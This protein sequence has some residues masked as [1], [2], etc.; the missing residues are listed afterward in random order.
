MKAVSHEFGHLLHYTTSYLGLTHFLFWAKSI[1]AIDNQ[2]HE[3]ET[4]TAATR[5]ILDPARGQQRYSIDDEYYFE[6]RYDLFDK[7]RSQHETWVVHEITGGLF[8]TDGQISAHR[9]WGTR[10]SLESEDGQ[11]PESFIRIPVGLRT[12]L[13]HMATA[14]DFFLALHL[15]EPDQLRAI[16]EMASEPSTLHYAC[17]AHLVAVRLKREYGSDAADPARQAAGEIVAL[18]AGIPFDSDE[19][20]SLLR[21]YAAH[22]RQDLVPHMNFPRPSFVFPVLLEAAIQGG[23]NFDNSLD[24]IEERADR[25][26]SEIGLSRI[27]EFWDA[28]R[29]LSQ[30]VKNVLSDHRQDRV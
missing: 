7:A 12:I 19:V 10:F 3:D 6:P 14:V 16:Q 17:L 24:G 2:G 13:E 1:A 5:N 29:S 22:Y 23:I 11:A 20:W 28:T 26:L 15:R 4:V 25:I 9:F 8:Y 30:T 27:S 18:L 21:N